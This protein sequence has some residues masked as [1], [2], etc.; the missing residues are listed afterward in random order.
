MTA[1]PLELLLPGGPATLV[2]GSFAA[3]QP[4]YERDGVVLDVDVTVPPELDHNW[5][6]DGSFLRLR[7]EPGACGVAICTKTLGVPGVFDRAREV[8]RIRAEMDAAARVVVIKQKRKRA[9]APAPLVVPVAAAE[10]LVME[11]V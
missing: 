10:Q 11:L 8:D 6:W 1:V 2:P 4:R 7:T 9:A 3:N 5:F